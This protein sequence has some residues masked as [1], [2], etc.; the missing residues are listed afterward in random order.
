M[1]QVDLIVERGK[2]GKAANRIPSLHN[3]ILF[4][5]GEAQSGVL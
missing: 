3:R 5:R 2:L 1:V 4:V